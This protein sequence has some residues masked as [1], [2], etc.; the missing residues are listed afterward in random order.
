[1]VSSNTSILDTVSRGLPA[2]FIINLT[3]GPNIATTSLDFVDRGL[4]TEYLQDAPPATTSIPNMSA[5]IPE[6][7]VMFRTYE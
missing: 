5:Y 4:P 6:E 1:M 2:T 3:T 7:T